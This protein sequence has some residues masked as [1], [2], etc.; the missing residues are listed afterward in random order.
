MKIIVA[1]GASGGHVFPA[2]SVARQLRA[3]GHEVL[4]VGA[5]RQWGKFI[6]DQNF[7]L[8]EFSAQG[9]GLKSLKY[10]LVSTGCMLKSCII[11]FK[12]IRDYRPERILGFGGYASFPVVLMG[13]FQ[14]IVTAIHEQNVV[15]GRANK[16]LGRFVKKIF[17]SFKQSCRYFPKQKT[18]V[19][20]YP[21]RVFQQSLS[22]GACRQEFGLVPERLTIAVCGGSQGSRTLNQAMVKAVELLKSEIDFQVVHITGEEDQQIVSMAYAHQGITFKVVP[23]FEVIEK[24]YQAADIIVARAGAGSI[25]EIACFRLPA[26][27]VPYPYAGDH[28]KYN[29]RVLA[30]EGL[31]V[32]I[33]EKSLT[34]D[35][36]SQ[37]ILCLLRRVTPLQSDETGVL[38]RKDSAEYIAEML[39][40]GCA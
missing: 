26:I 16:I 37:E 3:Q 34:A 36:L 7:P 24:I 33:E 14:G 13:C 27:I 2:L 25:H 39:A 22:K 35:R 28:Q 8:K 40:G 21:L 38:C 29:A 12:I 10:A 18:V 31:G 15:P 1:T 30:G 4:F 32:V 6:R 20:G 17:V 19:S 9:M 23:F 5:F 11:V